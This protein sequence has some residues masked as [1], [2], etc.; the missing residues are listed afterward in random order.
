[1]S[2]KDK[3]STEILAKLHEETQTLRADNERLHASLDAAQGSRA[4]LKAELD[5]WK[6]TALEKDAEIEAS[7]KGAQQAAEVKQRL[8]ADL[9]VAREEKKL[10]EQVCIQ[11]AIMTDH[12]AFLLA[13]ARARAQARVCALSFVA[14]SLW[15][16]GMA[17]HVR[18]MKEKDIRRQACITYGSAGACAP[19]AGGAE[20]SRGGGRQAALRAGRQQAE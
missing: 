15:H 5:S 8:E 1:M 17:A 6:K 16:G 20:A 10:I 3:L 13:C 9:V 18:P 14:S 12:I 11:F 7:A 2:G 4:E 19:A